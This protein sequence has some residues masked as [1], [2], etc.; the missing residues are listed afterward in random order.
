MITETLEKLLQTSSLANID[1][2]TQLS[3][4]VINKITG[5]IAS[6]VNQLTQ[7]NALLRKINAF[8]KIFKEI[9]VSI[10]EEKTE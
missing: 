4:W 9:K 7:N 1:P 6:N 5:G 2:Q 3:E 8:A 10:A